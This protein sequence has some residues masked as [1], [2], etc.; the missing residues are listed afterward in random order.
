MNVEIMVERLFQVLITG[1]R[2]G[3]TTIIDEA[4][5]GGMSGEEQAHDLFWP[6]LEMVSSLYRADQLTT[7]AHHYATRLMRRLIDQA[8]VTYTQLPSASQ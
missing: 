8:Q 5:A 2:T 6:I 1:D 3:A 4:R 7:L